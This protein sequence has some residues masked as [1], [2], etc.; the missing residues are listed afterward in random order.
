[1]NVDV[2]EGERRIEEEDEESTEEHLEEDVADDLDVGDEDDDASTGLGI[3][4]TANPD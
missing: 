1:M 4:T 2:N 3:A